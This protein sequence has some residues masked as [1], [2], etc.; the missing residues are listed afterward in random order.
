MTKIHMSLKSHDKTRGGGARNVRRKTTGPTSASQALV[1]DLDLKVTI[2]ANYLYGNN[3]DPSTGR[4]KIF[5]RLHQ[6]PVIDHVNNVEQIRLRQS[7]F[8]TN[9]QIQINISA[10]LRAD[11]INVRA[12]TSTF[13]Q[14]YALFIDNVI[15][16]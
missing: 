5:D 3:F 6:N 14:D 2:G 15:G 9:T 13:Q 10:T 7:D 16:Q 11:A 12:P 8:G 1:N 4:S